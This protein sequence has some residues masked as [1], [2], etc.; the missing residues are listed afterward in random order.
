M[1]GPAR[2]AVLRHNTRRS[3]EAT[4][5]AAPRAAPLVGAGSPGGGTGVREC[6]GASVPVH[7]VGGEHIGLDLGRCGARDTERKKVRL[8][9]RAV[10]RSRFFNIPH[11]L[12]AT[13]SI[14][15]VY[16]FGRFLCGY[17]AASGTASP[18]DAQVTVGGILFIN[19][20]D[21]QDINVAGRSSVLTFT[22]CFL[23]RGLYQIFVTADARRDDGVIDSADADA[24]PVTPPAT[25]P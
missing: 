1:L 13:A 24:G 16:V 18:S 2:P 7:S 25:M 10:T 8:R 4:S 15:A 14:W 3:H 6:H 11:S 12:T 9:Q 21:V 19:S 17:G 23:T 5:S 22:R 20:I